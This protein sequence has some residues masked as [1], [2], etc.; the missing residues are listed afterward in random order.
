VKA[1]TRIVILL[2]AL[3]ALSGMLLRLLDTDSP[4]RV[5]VVQITGEINQ[6][7]AAHLSRALASAEEQP[8]RAVVLLINTPGGR[9]DSALAMKDAILDS[10]KP[11]IALVDRHALSAGALITLAAD[12]IYMVPGSIMGAATPVDAFTGQTADEKI[13][14]AVRSAFAATADAK[15]RDPDVAQ[16][17]VDPDVFIEGLSESGRLLTLT[18]SQ[19]QQWGYSEGLVSGMDELLARRNLNNLAVATSSPGFL[20]RLV[21]VLTHPLVSIV[22]LA[23]GI[24]GLIIEFQTSGWGVGAALA[25]AALGLFFFGHFVA[26]IAGWEG[27]FL[28][29]LGMGLILLEVFVIPGVG[30]AAGLGILAILGGIY[31]SLVRD[32]SS[33]DQ[34]A[35]AG[36]ILGMALTLVAV[37]TWLSLTYLPRTRA[38]K[39]LLLMEALQGR[40]NGTAVQQRQRADAGLLGAT[41]VAT[42][43]LRPSGWAEIN[44]KQVDVVTQGEWLEQGE[45]VEVIEDSGYRRVV[46][47]VPS[48]DRETQPTAGG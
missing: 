11:T 10:P 20:E 22:L 46:R 39:G 37:G 38:F 12:E 35:R 29:L 9:L 36:Y 42:T 25:L 24:L 33:S 3:I 13:V 17:M 4:E 21:Q 27:V 26:G 45:E 40:Q 16:A 31:I 7:Q 28:V 2:L 8:V 14:S 43:D 30:I 34:L 23:V 47:P 32:L 6:A 41:G 5:L 1:R 19:A 18:A 48:A 15:G 44:G